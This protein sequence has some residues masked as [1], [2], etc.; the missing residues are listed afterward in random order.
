MTICESGIDW[1][2]LN[3]SILDKIFRK[4]TIM[5]RIKAESVCKRWK[6]ILR[7]KSFWT[8]IN[9]KNELLDGQVGN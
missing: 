4:L 2:H 3:E 1:R 8:S 6:K 9:S 5:E 7:S